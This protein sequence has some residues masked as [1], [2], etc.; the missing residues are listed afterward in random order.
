LNTKGARLEP[1]ADLYA[2]A[3]IMAS[4]IRG[5]DHCARVIPVVILPRFLAGSKL[6]FT[7]SYSAT[8]PQSGNWVMQM[9]TFKGT[10]Q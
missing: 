6:H 2:L 1:S 8:A 5:Q 4:Q 3:E 7:G 10:G 9:A